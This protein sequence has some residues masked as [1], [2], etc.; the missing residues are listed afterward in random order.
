MQHPKTDTVVTTEPGPT[1]L[2]S[3]NQNL[4]D[5]RFYF[6]LFSVL[7]RFLFQ[8]C[9]DPNPWLDPNGRSE[10]EPGLLRRFYLSNHKHFF[11]SFSCGSTFSFGQAHNH[12]QIQSNSVGPY[13]L[14]KYIYK[15]SHYMPF[16]NDI[17]KSSFRV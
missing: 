17:Q 2:A 6:F 10:P 9:H 15:E 16:Q 5:P 12:L 8:K 13:T 3:P 11:Y 1:R 7:L 4:E 14:T